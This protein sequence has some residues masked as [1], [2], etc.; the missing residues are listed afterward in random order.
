MA[1]RRGRVILGGLVALVI[2][3]VWRTV[4]LERE[5]R[6]LTTAY[7]QA[8][9]TVQQ[10]EG[11]L[12]GAREI[13]EHQATE[14]AGLQDELQSAQH[15]LEATRADLAGLQRDYARLRVAHTTLTAEKTAL[16]AKLS[17]LT[18]LKL[19]VRDLKQKIHRERWAAW[20]QR[21]QVQREADQQRLASGNRGYL[22]R[23]GHPTL[24]FE[25]KLRVHVLEPQSR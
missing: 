7:E 1:A 6:R 18:Q 5:Q 4:T 21:I 9:R 14:F 19:A 3:A 8:Q 24:R 13:I 10:L 16:E 17:D 12:A 15:Q 2:A 20:S 11:E 23:D 25:T 22:L